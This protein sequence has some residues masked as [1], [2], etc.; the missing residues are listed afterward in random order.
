MKYLLAVLF[1]QFALAAQ[2]TKIIT[3]TWDFN[4]AEQSVFQYYVFEEVGGQ[5]VWFG[6][7][8]DAGGYSKSGFYT[9]GS[10]NVVTLEVDASVE[11]HFYLL[12]QNQFG[13]SNFS[14]ECVVPV[15]VPG[16]PTPP[17]SL[18]YQQIFLQ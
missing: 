14:N 4:P 12:A 3:L 10:H 17:L 13:F 11:H 15:Y 8:H 6:S 5:Y 7:V 9:N 1:T 18:S 16:V 2:V